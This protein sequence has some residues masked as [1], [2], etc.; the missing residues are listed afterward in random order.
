M[1]ITKLNS[2]FGKLKVKYDRGETNTSEYKK[3]IREYKK[4]IEQWWKFNKEE[5]K[6]IKKIFTK[7][8]TSRG[9]FYDFF[10]SN[11][12]I[13]KAFDEIFKAFKNH[14]S[15]M[16]AI[17]SVLLNFEL[18]KEDNLKILRIIQDLIVKVDFDEE[19][20]KEEIKTI[21]K[22][23]KLD[24]Q[25]NDKN[26]RNLKE[27]YNEIDKR[28]ES[29]FNSGEYKKEEVAKLGKKT[30]TMK[31]ETEKLMTKCNFI[32]I[33]G[34][35]ATRH[36]VSNNYFSA[37]EVIEKLNNN[38]NDIK[39]VVAFHEGLNNS[40][41]DSSLNK[42]VS[43]KD[44]DEKIEFIYDKIIDTRKKGMIE[45]EKKINRLFEN[46]IKERKVSKIKR[47]LPPTPQ[48]KNSTRNSLVMNSVANSSNEDF[49]KIR[50]GNNSLDRP[51]STQKR[52]ST[53]LTSE[54]RKNLNDALN[55]ALKN[56]PS[57]PGSSNNARKKTLPILKEDNNQS[58]T[59]QTDEKNKKQK[60]SKSKKLKKRISHIFGRNKG[61]KS[62]KS[63]DYSSVN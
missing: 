48:R 60:T 38:L 57:R 22:F 36:E 47:P 46:F 26:L 44:G 35:A 41:E 14:K 61:E 40:F 6:K 21:S 39:N 32:N 10:N 16:E 55:A 1:V 25:E 52:S 5:I 2:S 59:T 19:D 45:Y 20:V 56:R 37:S 31:N 58:S 28:L 27:F 13:E 43:K 17:E 23:I 7:Y 18:N 8:N 29:L 3:K 33:V 62:S 63:D 9:M 12:S 42:L 34:I 54:E 49:G 11:N 53:S 24:E 50:K 51:V 15:S 4:N 30:M